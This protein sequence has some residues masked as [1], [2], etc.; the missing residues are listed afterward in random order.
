[1]VAGG[2]VARV[3]WH[4]K[5]KGSTIVAQ[6]SLDFSPYLRYCAMMRS[7]T[8]CIIVLCLT[9]FA[10]PQLTNQLLTQGLELQ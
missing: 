9:A 5:K 3:S 10:N 7:D 4:Q 1:M 6:N 2:L 8:L